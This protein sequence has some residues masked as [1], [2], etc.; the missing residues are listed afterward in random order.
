MQFDAKAACKLMW[1]KGVVGGGGF[2]CLAWG[3]TCNNL[4][5]R[6]SSRHQAE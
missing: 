6:F 1:Q 2:K 3:M 5:E 4:L